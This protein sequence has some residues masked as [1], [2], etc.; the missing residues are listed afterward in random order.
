[1]QFYEYFESIW[2]IFL[3][4]FLNFTRSN[5]FRPASKR[6]LNITRAECKLYKLNKLD[7][8]YKVVCV[9][10]YLFVCMFA[11]ICLSLPLSVSL[12]VSVSESCVD[13]IQRLKNVMH[14]EWKIKFI[15][16]VDTTISKNPMLFLCYYQTSAVH[17]KFFA[18]QSLSRVIR[19]NGLSA[20]QSAT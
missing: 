4:W 20:Q 17:R 7:F 12:L 18:H 6:L 9:K 15:R 13:S 11:R 2:S 5:N 3:D 19:P 16:S 1:M 8:W 14:I 10:V